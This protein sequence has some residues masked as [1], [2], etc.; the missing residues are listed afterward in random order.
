MA[1]IN[2][3]VYQGGK[4]LDS[5]CDWANSVYAT[6]IMAAIFPIYFEA[7]AKGAGVN[8][9]TMWGLGTSVATLAIASAS[10]LCWERSAILWA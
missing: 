10:R 3:K 4:K 1:S 8:N 9:V 2:T 7:V 5:L 6:N